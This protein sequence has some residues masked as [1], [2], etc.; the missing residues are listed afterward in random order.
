MTKKQAFIERYTNC[1]NTNDYYVERP[2]WY[3]TDPRILFSQIIKQ[4]MYEM[5]M[6]I[7]THIRGTGKIE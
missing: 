2:K 3:G 4:K 1:V 6:V 5:Q 7:Q